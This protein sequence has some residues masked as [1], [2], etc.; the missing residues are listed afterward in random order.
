MISEYEECRMCL[1]GP[2]YRIEGAVTPLDRRRHT[3]VTYTGPK[4][5][6][7]V[8]PVCDFIAA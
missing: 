3:E 5:D 6:I 7:R 8:C 4:K 2:A 1:E